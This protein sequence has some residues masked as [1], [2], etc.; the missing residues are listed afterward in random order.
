MADLTRLLLGMTLLVAACA[1][2]GLP[3][4][5][6]PAPTPVIGQTPASSSATGQASG[7]AR[8]ARPPSPCAL[9][10][11]EQAA[12]LVPL[13][14][15]H[16]EGG[17]E[18]ARVCTWTGPD[19]PYLPDSS[20]YE[21]RVQV[22]HSP[23]VADAENV[24]KSWSDTFAT[25]PR[26]VPG[27]A[28]AATAFDRRVDDAAETGVGYRA[29]NLVVIIDYIRRGPLDQRMRDNAVKAAR[30]T[31]ARLD[32]PEPQP[33]PNA[34]RFAGPPDA[35]PLLDPSDRPGQAGPECT[36]DD[37]T[38]RVRHV[39]AR[40]TTP[41]PTAAKELFE[42]LAAQAAGGVGTS[43][44]PRTDVTVSPVKRVGAVGEAAFTQEESGYTIFG[45]P[46][47]ITLW[48]R[49]SNL[50]VEVEVAGEGRKVTPELRRRAVTI[51]QQVVR[52]LPGG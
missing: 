41:G 2:G 36:S 5:Q 7:P 27:L 17:E 38:V 49:V 28:D 6:T 35:C 23:Q 10:T 40:G 34:G 45:S 29:S 24:F 22:R 19:G 11:A 1:P 4:R 15:G 8:F 21:L 37:V 18:Q 26:D 43:D 39:P 44:E 48:T 32:A 47:R 20:R 3:A 31:V 42:L 25:S 13:L 46:T 52:R 9:I 12:G 30:W 14:V 50:V 33:D 51:A 16:Q